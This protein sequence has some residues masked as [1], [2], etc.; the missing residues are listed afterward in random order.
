MKEI[1]ASFQY[2]IQLRFSKYIY[3]LYIYIYIYIYIHII[4]I[5]IYIYI[6][7]KYIL[8]CIIHVII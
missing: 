7:N 4:Y 3:I 2:S 1:I 8:S 6:Y 5:Y